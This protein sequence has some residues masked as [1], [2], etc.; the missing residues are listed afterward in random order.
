MKIE[1]DLDTIPIFFKS[2]HDPS[3]CWL[4]DKIKH[5]RNSMVAFFPFFP[6]KIDLK[7]QKTMGQY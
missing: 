1:C 5:V 7:V 4:S 6:R 2:Y 3:H